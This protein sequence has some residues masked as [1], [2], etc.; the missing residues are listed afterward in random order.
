MKPLSVKELYKECEK[1]IK[2]GNADKIIMLS[3]DDEGNGF[4]YCWY[5][6][7]AIEDSISEFNDYLIDE[8]IA[9]KEDTII[10]G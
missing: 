10:L 8:K 1:Q 3:D 9:K 7:S 6:F 2:K 5:T 4:H